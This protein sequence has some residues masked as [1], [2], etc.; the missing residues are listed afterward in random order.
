MNFS[1]IIKFDKEAYKE[2]SELQQ[3]VQ[4]GSK[5]QKNPSYEQLLA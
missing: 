1:T 4:E 5:S 3:N 2:Y